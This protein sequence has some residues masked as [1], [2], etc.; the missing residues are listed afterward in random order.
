MTPRTGSEPLVAGV[1]GGATR[2]RLVLADRR[3]GILVRGRGGPSL[4]GAGRDRDVADE[5]LGRM[6][7]LVA[8]VGGRFPLEAVCAGL[9]GAGS[10]EAR[11]LLAVRLQEWG[12]ARRARVLTDAE[13]AFADAFGEGAGIL[14]IAGTGSV[15][16]ARG[17][18]GSDL[19]RV[20]GWGA[21]LGD[22]GSGYRIGLEGLQ[23]AIRAAEG[24]GP[25]TGLTEALFRESGASTVHDLLGWSR[26]TGKSGIASLAPVVSE[27]AGEGDEAASAV[28]DRAVEAL[29]DHVRTLARR[30][31]RAPPPQVALV[32]GLIEE[33]GSLR[34][35]LLR[36]LE[37]SGFH[38]LR[39]PVDP[40]RGAV[41]I[42]LTL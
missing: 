26:N 11:T 10:E 32:G 29:V 6:R 13:V 40:A 17:A 12:V 24:R 1:D 18:E 8:E 31:E 30:I 4:L 7:E 41:R 33:G 25:E 5:L 42:A 22:E 2:T 39:R 9:A 36:R 27:V 23:A 37:L 3:G 21:L 14:L 15:A 20:G 16:M 28:V 19:E 35:R 34:P 38:V